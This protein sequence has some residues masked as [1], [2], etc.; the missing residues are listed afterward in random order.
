MQRRRLGVLVGALLACG[1]LVIAGSAGAGKPA[2]APTPKVGG[3][4]VFGAEQE[5][6]GWNNYLDCCNA[7]WGSFWTNEVLQGAYTV[8]PDFSYK[9]TLI[10]GAD[11]VTKPKF[12]LTFH[13]RPEAK[14][15]DG[16][17]ITADD[18]IFT[19]KTFVNPKWDI[20]SRNGWDQIV[21]AKKINAKTVEFTYKTPFAGWKDQWSSQIYPL[22]ALQG[23]DFNH[24]WDNGIINPKN[25]KPIASGPFMWGGYVKGQSVTLVRNPNWWGPHKAYLDKIVAKFIT[26]TNSEIQAIRGGEVQAIYPQPQLALADLGKVS[27]LAIQSRAGTTL[28]HIDYQLGSKGG[29]L[30]SAPWVRQAIAYAIDRA[31]T[32]KQLFASLN[33]KLPVLN[34]LVYV[35]NA[36]QYQAHFGQYTYNPAKVASLMS[37]HGCT[38]GGDGIYSCNGQRMSYKFTSTAGNK[39]RELAFEIFQAQAKKAGIELVSAFAPASIVFGPTVFEAGNFDLFMYAWVGTADPQGWGP[40]YECGGSDNHKGYCSTKVTKLLE[41]ADRELDPTK[42]AAL[43]NQADKF[44]S[45][46]LPALPLYQKPT[47][48]VYSK[49]LHGVIDNPTNQGAAWNAEDWWLG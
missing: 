41:A 3:T 33:P 9:E 26:D 31:A 45:L 11:V 19:W 5:P 6:P 7:F 8:L 49:K 18:F 37:A 39:L 28:E 2:A 22:H 21:S 48:F 27:T 40:I 29:P 36:Q 32:V 34:S 24:V 35:S 13:I 30:E 47:Y 25:H 16:V 17:P 12:K 4:L 46:G 20:V 42:R 15:S 43:V 44:M 38:K 14:W 1:A 10:T 23:E